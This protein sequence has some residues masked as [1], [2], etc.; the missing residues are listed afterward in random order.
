MAKAARIQCINTQDRDDARER[1]THVG[2]VNR[3]G[4]RWKLSQQWAI[5]LLEGGWRCWVSVDGD[6]VW[7][8]VATTRDGHKYIKTEIDGDSPENLLGL[9]ECP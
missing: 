8:V 5:K 2:G 9:P 1:I 6:R 4:A 7:C 3:D